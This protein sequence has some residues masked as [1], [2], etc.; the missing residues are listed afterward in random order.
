[1][2]VGRL[3]ALAPLLA[4]VSLD[5]CLLTARG[6]HSRSVHF[7]LPAHVVPLCQS[8]M[9]E[10]PPLLLCL[11]RGEV[12]LC[13]RALIAFHLDKSIAG[14]HRRWSARHEKAFHLGKCKSIAGQH[15]RWSGRDEKAPQSSKKSVRYRISGTR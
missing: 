4:V 6:D 1:M 8:S 2:A 3:L 13:N 15:R 11:W 14:W 7:H 9:R 10:N 12:S 5:L